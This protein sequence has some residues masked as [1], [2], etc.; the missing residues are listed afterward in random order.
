VTP[1]VLREWF[2]AEMGRLGVP[3]RYVDAL[4]GRVPKSV[5][6]KHY[7]DYLPVKLKEIYDSAEV[8]T[9]N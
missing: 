3:D 6:A 9:L 4:C 5:L 1:Q 2:C 8:K 7:T